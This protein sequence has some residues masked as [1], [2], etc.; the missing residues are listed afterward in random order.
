MI[1]EVEVSEQADSDLRGIFEYIAFE[2]Q[3]PENASGQLDRLEEQILS[4]DTMP[5]RYRKYV[6]EPWKSRGLCELTE[7]NYVVTAEKAIK[8]ICGKKD[9]RGRT[10]APVTT[11]KI[12]NLLAMTAAIYNDVIVC[13]SEKLSTE[14]VGRIQYMKIRFVYE[15]GREPKVKELVE[16]ASLLEHL[17]EIGSSRT[18]YLLF[19]RY[20]EALVA[21]RKFYGGHDE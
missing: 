4:L 5:E 3:S 10:V 12:R 16:K 7:D 15:A 13:T 8:E 19:S 21:Y 2:L 6:F 18:Q 11:S 1:Y 20:M 14:I 9:R 17:E